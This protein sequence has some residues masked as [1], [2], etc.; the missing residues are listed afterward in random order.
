[1]SRPGIIERMR[2]E[3]QPVSMATANL[4]LTPQEAKEF[5]DTLGQLLRDGNYDAPYHIAS[6]DFQTEVTM[7]LDRK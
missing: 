3:E 4:W 1:V 2:I 6:A 7:M 5:M